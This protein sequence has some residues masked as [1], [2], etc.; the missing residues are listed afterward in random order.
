MDSH[1]ST[2]RLNKFLAERLGVSRREA[3][4]LISSGKVTID[5][6]VAVLGARVD[7]SSKVCYNGKILI[8]LLT[9]FVRAVLRAIRP[10]CMNY[11]Q[12]NI[13]N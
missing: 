10:L 2:V 5:D 4:D 8:S 11:Y 6:K 7:N 12:K 3:D 9:M 13:R 1:P